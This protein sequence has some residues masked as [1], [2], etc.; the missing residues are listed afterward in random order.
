MHIHVHA[1]VRVSVCVHTRVCVH[2]RACAVVSHGNRKPEE[3]MCKVRD[4]G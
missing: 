2:A 1:Y 3:K 4:T